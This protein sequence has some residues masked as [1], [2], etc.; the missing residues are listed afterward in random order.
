[1]YTIASIEH[2]EGRYKRNHAPFIERHNNGLCLCT[3]DF[4]KSIEFAVDEEGGPSLCAPSAGTTTP[5]PRSTG[6]P[7]ASPLP[8]P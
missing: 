1:M 8:A 7:S 3:G 6:S 5:S 2:P 4:L